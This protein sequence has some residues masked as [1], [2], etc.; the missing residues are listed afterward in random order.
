MPRKINKSRRS[1]RRVTK[2]KRSPPKAYA[3]ERTDIQKYQSTFRLTAAASGGF[4][5]PIDLSLIDQLST[6]QATWALWRLERFTARC[7]PA[8][9]ESG[10]YAICPYESAAGATPVTPTNLVA[11]LDG[12]GKL[13]A[14]TNAAENRS[15]VRYKRK[16]VNEATYTGTTT[17]SA[18]GGDP[19][20]SF[21]LEL[22]GAA[23]VGAIFY[24]E[25]DAWFSFRE[26]TQFTTR[27]MRIATISSPP[28]SNRP[29]ASAS[30]D[31][32]TLTDTDIADLMRARLS[33][34][35]APISI[36]KA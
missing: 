12:G 3:G 20:L 23:V 6:L 24:I 25:I 18:L 19:G 32:D 28:S 30:S 2:S 15:T 7:T 36:R 14:C 33:L 9:A 10:A 17:T 27:S 13:K 8:A 11:V 34:G 1:K 21:Y 31:F 29:T 4:I 35:N 26:P 5:L 16:T 22:F